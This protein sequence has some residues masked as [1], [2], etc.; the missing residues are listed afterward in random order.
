[1]GSEFMGLHI[2]RTHIAIE[3]EAIRDWDCDLQPY[4]FLGDAHG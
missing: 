4:V 2:L 1:M 3:L